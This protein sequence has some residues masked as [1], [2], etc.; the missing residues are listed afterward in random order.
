MPKNAQ[1]QVVCINQGT[2][3]NSGSSVHTMQKMEGNGMLPRRDKDTDGV[4]FLNPTK[5]I[6]TDMYICT[7]CKYIE[8]YIN[9]EV[10]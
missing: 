5:G 6:A 7:N 9:P 10:M 4:P 2:S 3:I 8:L 1:D